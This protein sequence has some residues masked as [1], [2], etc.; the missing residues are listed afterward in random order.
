MDAAP[1]SPERLPSHVGV[2]RGRWEG[3]QLVVETTH[4]VPENEGSRFPGSPALQVTERF[5]LQEG[6]E[7]GKQLVDEITIRDPLVYSQPI[8][9]RMVYKRARN[10]VTVGEYICNED[11]WDQHLDGSTSRIPWR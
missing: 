3:S 5:S 11:I 7:L 8:T 1:V 10:D 4:I 9:I 2:S 6:A